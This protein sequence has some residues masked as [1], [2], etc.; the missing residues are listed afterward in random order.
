MRVQSKGTTAPDLAGLRLSGCGRV[1]DH[2]PEAHPGGDRGRGWWKGHRLLGEPLSVI[3]Q[4]AS[5]AAEENQ[6]SRERIRLQ[7]LLA[8]AEGG[9]FVWWPSGNEPHGCWKPIRHRCCW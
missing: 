4:D 2:A 1:S 9:R 3:D 8:G 5:P 7:F 6:A